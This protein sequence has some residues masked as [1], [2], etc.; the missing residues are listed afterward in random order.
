M[1]THA[2][3]RQH[4]SRCAVPGV[5]AVITPKSGGSHAARDGARKA[6]LRVLD[7][8]CSRSAALK[9]AD[10]GQSGTG[11]HVDQRTAGVD[12]IIVA[13]LHAI[14]LLPPLP[15]ESPI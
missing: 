7:A 6:Q 5:V 15:T 4:R 8:K 12:I 9:E 3:Q 1:R 11:P 2:T 14:A 13:L 10:A